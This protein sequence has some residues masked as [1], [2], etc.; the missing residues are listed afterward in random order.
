MSHVQK[1]CS[2]YY[3]T[4]NIDYYEHTISFMNTMVEV[5]NVWLRCKAENLP[6]DGATVTADPMVNCHFPPILGRIC[7]RK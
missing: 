3:I 6:T 2:N 1:K 5:D 4:N 7:V